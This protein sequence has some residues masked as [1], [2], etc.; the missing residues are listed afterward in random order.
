MVWKIVAGVSIAFAAIT[1]AAPSAPPAYAELM[2]AQGTP[3]AQQF[4]PY[5]QNWNPCGGRCPVSRCKWSWWRG[6]YRCVW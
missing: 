1:A 5:L 2:V 4:G 3:A 6:T